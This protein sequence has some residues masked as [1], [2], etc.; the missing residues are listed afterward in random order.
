M[1]KAVKKVAITEIKKNK[2][3]EVEKIK[4]SSKTAV[5]H[6]NKKPVKSVVKKEKNKIEKIEKTNVSIAKKT[7]QTKKSLTPEQ[8]KEWMKQDEVQV[9]EDDV[10]NS[11]GNE[12]F[13]ETDHAQFLQLAEQAN[14]IKKALLM[15]KPEVHPDFDGI[16]CVECGVVIPEGRIKLKKIRC[17]DCQEEIDF[18][19]KRKN[20][21]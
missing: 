16:H 7:N 14:L 11:F 8:W 19:N 20:L 9:V 1:K 15:N 13:D 17:V 6:K 18:I 3:E 12:V 2:K 5:Y 21:T 10:E 4:T